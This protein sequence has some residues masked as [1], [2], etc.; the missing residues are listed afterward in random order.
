M[1]STDDSEQRGIDGHDTSTERSPIVG[2][3]LQRDKR[4]AEAA[5]LLGAIALETINQSEWNLLR[6]E[7]SRYRDTV[8]TTWATTAVGAPLADL[9]ERDRQVLT[10]ISNGWTNSRIAST[11]EISVGT[12]KNIVNKLGRALLEDSAAND[13]NTPEHIEGLRVRIAVQAVRRGLI[14]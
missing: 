2:L 3:P 8:L 11:F 9:D 4:D 7:L 5:A 14:K 1:N 13:A 6:D 12:V 10:H